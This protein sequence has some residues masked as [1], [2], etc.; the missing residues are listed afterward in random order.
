MSQTNLGHV[1]VV[2]DP[3]L[4]TPQRLAAL[5]QS[6]T[7][8]PGRAIPLTATA[9]SAYL[10]PRL[11]ASPPWRLVSANADEM[12]R[13]D[14][15]PV[16]RATFVY[17]GAGPSNW[18]TVSQQPYRGLSEI[19]VPLPIG[20]LSVGG[21]T[22]VVM[23]RGDVLTMFWERGDQFIEIQGQGLAPS[24]AARIAESLQ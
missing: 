16:T 2:V 18:V 12:P 17:Q 7:Q 22:A 1:S 15:G 13:R 24:D 6:G 19:T 10:Q 8:R 3:S 5:R 21:R 23:T 14:G 4:E 20:E 9:L 11:L